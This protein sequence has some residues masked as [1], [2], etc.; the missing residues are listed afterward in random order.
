MLQSIMKNKV[1]EE[2]M[3]ARNL[4]SKEGRED[5]KR[6]MDISAKSMRKGSKAVS[7][8]QIQRAH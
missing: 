2:R 4:S 3:N 5:T 1:G 7:V 6:G 8:T